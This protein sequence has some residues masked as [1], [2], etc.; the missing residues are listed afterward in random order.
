MEVRGASRA[1]TV[2]G[3]AVLI[4]AHRR[5]R[6]HRAADA[7]RGIS[8][9]V[10][11]A[12]YGL[13][14]DVSGAHP[15]PPSHVSLRAAALPRPA[16]LALGSF[17]ALGLVVTATASLV[18][19]S[20]PDPFRAA[21]GAAAALTGG[22][23][24]YGV[25][26]V[27][28]G[29]LLRSRPAT[30]LLSS[31]IVSFVVTTELSRRGAWR[32]WC[33]GWAA[34]VLLAAL[35]DRSLGV[36]GLPVAVAVGWAAG[37]LARW[38]LG[39]TSTGPSVA[40][41][42]EWLAS[43]SLR[44]GGLAPAATE[45]G[46]LHGT[47]A[48]GRGV[49]VRV[50]D[51]DS[52]LAEVARTAWYRLRLRF[53]VDPAP[54]AT[55]PRRLRDLALAGFLA[56]DAGVDAPRP[57]LLEEFGDRT[58]V[59]VSTRPAG[60][61]LEPPVDGDQAAGCFD[62]LRR[63]HG[64]GLALGRVR[65]ADFARTGA[66]PALVSLRRSIPAS[67]AL[68][69]RLDLAQLLVAVAGASDPD[70][71]IGAMRKGYGPVDELAV[72]AVLQPVALAPWGWAGMRSAARCTGQ[73]RS[74]LTPAG[75]PVPSVP[76]ERFRW[77][78]VV[79][80]GTLVLVAYLLV[81]QLS[82][83]DLVGALG[84]MHLRWFAAAVGA[85]AVTYWSAGA[86]VAAFVAERPPLGEACLVQLSTSF[87]GVAMPSTVGLVAINARYLS[88]RR[89]DPSSIAAA[90][91]LSQA[92]NVAVTVMSV[93]VLGLLTGSG[94][95]QSRLA[96]G[97]DLLVGGV[98]A[99]AVAAAVLGIPQTR[100]RVARLLA[101]HVRALLPRLVEAVSRPGRLLAGAGAALLL[102]ASYAGALL[103]AL[104][105]VGARAPLL[106][107]AIVLLLGNFVGSAAP[108]PGGLGGVEAALAAGLAGI[109]IPA[110]EAI[111]AVI[112][113]RLATFWLPIPFGAVAYVGLR[114]AGRL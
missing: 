3:T 43:R 44:M 81:G 108:T 64:V 30:F 33:T 46:V 100:V 13:A 107:T 65:L 99:A 113:Y 91:T 63:V 103:A 90:M 38:A 22:A 80:I 112:V 47:L 16:M 4:A 75:E 34:A 52:R 109:G 82:S 74:R 84:R 67:S 79:S 31:M 42:M 60:T 5:A 78:T 9:L 61:P 57:L 83:V 69:R 94:V 70:T 28:P 53:P 24:A 26:S 25:V 110:H 105:A 88:R 73:V 96:P 71:A 85:S 45:P 77:R 21:R 66:Q 98:V 27:T 59:A 62:V 35:L 50:A 8:S 114:R 101:P 97:P 54:P 12:A 41:L 36:L 7:A 39:A 104:A 1:A 19:L 111:P 89:V 23:L 48:D 15:A 102:E 2:A 76:L 11:V 87:A 32:R 17:C 29:D 51:R 95:S 55:S 40:A 58:V 56:A 37:F 14:A 106:P 68:S 18:G 10:A 20:R 6:A 93:V 92:A 49:A 86:G 72:A